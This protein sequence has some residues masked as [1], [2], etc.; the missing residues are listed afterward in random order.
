[1]VD[2]GGVGPR[3]LL[4]DH[5]QSGAAVDDGISNERL[6]IDLDLCDVAEREITWCA[7]QRNLGNL[8]RISQLLQ[9]VPYLKALAAGSR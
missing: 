1:L 8:G 5:D 9:Q 2:F 3:E 6:V 7:L 4:D